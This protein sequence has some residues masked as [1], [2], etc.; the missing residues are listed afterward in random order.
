MEVDT[1]IASVLA[2]STRTRF[3]LAEA[4][5]DQTDCHKYTLL[6][7]GACFRTL[8]ANSGTWSH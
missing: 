4:S 2:V 1:A 3:C 5:N 8:R 7:C 6:R